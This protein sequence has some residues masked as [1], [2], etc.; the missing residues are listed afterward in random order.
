MTVA[1]S[2]PIHSCRKRD[3]GWQRGFLI[4]L[5]FRW[6]CFPACCRPDLKVQNPQCSFQFLSHP[7]SVY[8]QVN[9]LPWAAFFHVSGY[10]PKCCWE[11]LVIYLQSD[12]ETAKYRWYQNPNVCRNPYLLHKAMERFGLLHYQAERSTSPLACNSIALPL[13]F[14]RECHMLSQ[15][16]WGLRVLSFTLLYATELSKL[17]F[18]CYQLSNHPQS[19]PKCW[20]WG[21]SKLEG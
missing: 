12:R 9:S 6:C 3:I 4:L 18:L 16:S 19:A 8:L 20:F 13:I 1:A 2:H 7:S 15:D 5:A 21:M 10:R 14:R 17:C 11:Q